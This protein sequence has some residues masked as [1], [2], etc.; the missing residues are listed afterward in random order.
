MIRDAVAIPDIASHD[1]KVNAWEYYR[2][3]RDQDGMYSFMR[4]DGIRAWVVARYDDVL[5]VLKDDRLTK[6]PNYSEAPWYARA[7]MPLFAP[8]LNTMLNTDPPD[9]TRLRGLV[10]KAFTPR[11][12]EEMRGRV[13]KLT[14]ELLDGAAQR[15]RMDLIADYAQ[16]IPTMVICDM[17]GIPYADRDKFMRWSQRLVSVTTFN[18]GFQLLG[19]LF[20]MRGYLNNLFRQRRA[21]PKDDLTTALVSAREEDDALNDDEL[22]S[23]V[24][25]L[26]IAGHETT[27]N[28]IGNGALALIDHPDQRA[29]LAAEPDL[30]RTGVE[31]LLRYDSPVDQATD[32]FAPAPLDLCGARVGK[33]DLIMAS[34][35]SA[36]RDERQFANPDDLDL[37]R[38]NNK[39]LAFGNGIHYCL[40][41]PLARIEGALAIG[42]LVERFPGLR[43]SAPRES[44]RYRTSNVTRGL[45]SL[46]VRW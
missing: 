12:V 46:P 38:A 5:A 31:E 44:L 9:H 30:I 20:A 14:E 28:L 2:Q 7:I 40:G 42:R 37:A 11:R 36:N 17:L 33:G 1:F 26:L 29:R 34:L 4:K 35:A 3:M 19:I 15:G 16:I 45:E 18:E 39:H 22:I 27:V 21:D 41:A 24:M 13:E 6:R 23:M 32:R 10:H 43:L 25:L 8:M